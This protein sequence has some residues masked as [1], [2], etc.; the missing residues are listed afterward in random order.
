[1]AVHESGHAVVAKFSERAEPPHRISII[2]RGMSLGAT[3][4]RASG[5]DRHLM[6]EGELAARLRVLMGGYAA[7]RLVLATIST[8]AENDLK[9]ATHLASRMVAN[10]GMSDRLGPVFYEHD[11]EHPFLGQRIAVDGGTS[12][13]TA[14]AIEEEAR[15]LLGRALAEASKTLDD[16]RADLDRLAGAL[17]E[18]ESLE[19]AEIDEL[20]APRH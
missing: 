2:P 18:K 5:L 3:Q 1:V 13:A 19:R 15:V 14:A 11:V 20:L 6:D 16:H 4:Q 17:L 7:E 8:G 10:Y 12:A 9:E